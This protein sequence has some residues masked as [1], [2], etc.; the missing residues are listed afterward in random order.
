MGFVEEPKQ[1]VRTSSFTATA[2][3]VENEETFFPLKP[4]E[5]RLFILLRDFYNKLEGCGEDAVDADLVLD[6]LEANNTIREVFLI[7]DMKEMEEGLEAMQL[8][9]EG[10]VSWEEFLELVFDYRVNISADQEIKYE[11]PEA[12]DNRAKLKKWK[13]KKI[14]FK[15]RASKKKGGKKENKPV[16]SKKVEMKV[17]VPQPFK[18]NKREAVRKTKKTIRQQWLEDNLEGKKHEEDEFVHHTFKANPIPLTTT[19]P[20]FN[21]MMEEQQKRSEEVKQ[22]SREITK[23]REKPFSFYE[24]D[25]NFYIER[26]EARKNNVPE[27]LR[28]VKPFRAN[29][30]PQAVK[31]AMMSK[32][33]E[34]EE[35]IRAQ[36]KK[37]WAYELAQ[38][39]H[40][41]PRMQMHQREKANAPPKP[42]QAPPF[43]FEPFA[44]KPVPDYKKQQ[45][46][47]QRAL[48]RCKA[49]HAS[50]VP[51][52]FNFRETKKRAAIHDFM[53]QGVPQVDAMPRTTK[54]EIASLKKPS[55]NPP[56]TAKTMGMMELRRRQLEERKQRE[57][58][59]VAEDRQRKGKGSEVFAARYL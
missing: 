22:K 38:Q 8:G 52:P 54:G 36:R 40:L 55:I 2:T 43:S 20:L 27:P 41:P 44:A 56:T 13:R 28:N 59:K 51:K 57:L 53:D 45:D 7:E 34:E 18:F 32:M 19:M 42:P 24:R 10:L 12:E 11:V 15:N 21:Q 3:K 39:S 17:T 14:K 4:G 26:E 16:L 25:K 29:P 49:S 9:K 5:K 58:Q 1:R 23:A 50:T 37:Q 30:I 48:E 33:H 47:F 6:A 35:E 46:A 31:V